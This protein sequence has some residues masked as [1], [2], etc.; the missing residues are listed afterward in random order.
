MKCQFVLI[1]QVN[2]QSK[3]AQS[4]ASMRMNDEFGAMVGCPICGE[5]RTVW[6]NGQT[7]VNECGK[8]NAHD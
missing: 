4:A 3:N 5:I 6:A 2:R 8:A 7:E 1:E